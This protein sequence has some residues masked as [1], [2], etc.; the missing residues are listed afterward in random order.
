MESIGEAEEFM[1]LWLVF[2][3]VSMSQ[4]GLEKLNIEFNYDPETYLEDLE[5]YPCDIN[6][7]GS[8]Y[9]SLDV[10]CW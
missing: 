6:Y 4:T 10:Y 8:L 9:C 5:D 2:N 7:Y 3:E 1:K